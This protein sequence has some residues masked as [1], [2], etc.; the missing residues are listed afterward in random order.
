VRSTVPLY[1][2]SHKRACIR[3]HWHVFERRGPLHTHFCMNAIERAL[4]QSIARILN[5]HMTLF[6]SLSS[7]HFSPAPYTFFPLFSHHPSHL[8]TKPPIS[9]PKHTAITTISPPRRRCATATI[10]F[11]PIFFLIFFSLTKPNLSQNSYFAPFLSF[12]RH[13][14]FHGLCLCP[15]CVGYFYFCRGLG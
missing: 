7:P 14:S 11:T 5:H 4:M 10:P 3:T 15:F 13:K 9:T 1:N 6:R 12:Q 8:H 2:R